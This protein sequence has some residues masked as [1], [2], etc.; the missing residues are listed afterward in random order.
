MN[1][2]W[3]LNWKLGKYEKKNQKKENR[4]A[5]EKFVKVKEICSLRTFFDV[6]L[7]LVLVVRS[8]DGWDL[9][10]KGHLSHLNSLYST[11]FWH[12]MISRDF[13]FVRLCFVLIVFSFWRIT[14]TAQA[15]LRAR[16][17]YWPSCWSLYENTCAPFSAVVLLGVQGNRF[18]QST[19]WTFRSAIYVSF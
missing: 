7:V 13:S 18:R 17:N 12:A 3:L 10:S 14:E 5:V 4:K 6:F 15:W 9:W 1:T 11:I 16:P 19:F 8:I 2:Y